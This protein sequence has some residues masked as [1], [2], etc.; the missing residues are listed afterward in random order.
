MDL[1]AAPESILPPPMKK[2]KPE[3]S[4]PPKLTNPYSKLKPMT[5]TAKTY[6]IDDA[7]NAPSFDRSLV[8]MAFKL[9]TIATESHKTGKSTAHQ[10]AMEESR[11]R[12]DDRKATVFR[13]RK[14]QVKVLWYCS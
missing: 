6:S 14:H 2:L 10:L 3:I 9:P 5:S 11:R 12:N 13:E 1:S 8:P 7:L 4:A